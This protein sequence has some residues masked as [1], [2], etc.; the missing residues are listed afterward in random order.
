M[1][2]TPSFWD[3]TAFQLRLLDTSQMQLRQ[4]NGET[5]KTIDICVKNERRLFDGVACHPGSPISRELP[6]QNV[7]LT[8]HKPGGRARASAGIF[9]WKGLQE[10]LDSLILSEDNSLLEAP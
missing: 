5:Q 3:E 7:K 8:I 9:Q 1:S 10:D 2:L 6:L 4:K